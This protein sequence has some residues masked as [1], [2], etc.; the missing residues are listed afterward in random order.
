MKL[1]LFK[2]MEYGFESAGEETLEGCGDYVRLTEYVDVDFHRLPYGDAE[3][4]EIAI[5]DKQIKS[6]QAES[7][8]KIGRLNQRKAELLA[9]PGAEQ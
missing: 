5:I 2:H 6:E 9:L 8:V 1:A 3:K 4:A 7:E